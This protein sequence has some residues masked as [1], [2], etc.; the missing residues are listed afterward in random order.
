MNETSTAFIVRHNPQNLENPCKIP[1]L[2]LKYKK[3]QYS[4]ISYQKTYEAIEVSRE[5]IHT[6]CDRILSFFIH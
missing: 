2:T 5:E 4:K 1:S 3:K 6:K